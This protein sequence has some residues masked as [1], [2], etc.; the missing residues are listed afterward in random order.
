MSSSRRETLE[1]V[2]RSR[3]TPLAT[4]QPPKQYGPEV[5]GH[6]ISVLWDECAW[7]QG[8]VVQFSAI[9]DRHLVKYD[10]GDTK[11]HELGL[12]EAEGGIKWP[13]QEKATVANLDHERTAASKPPVRAGGLKRVKPSEATS[14]PSEAPSSAI[15]EAKSG[16]PKAKRGAQDER[17]ILPRKR[18]SVQANRREPTLR[19]KLHEH[20]LHPQCMPDNECDC[21]P[22]GVSCVG[23]HWRCDQC[24]F[25]VCSNC[26]EAS[27]EAEESSPAKESAPAKHNA[28]TKESA[29]AKEAASVG[30]G[31][32]GSRIEIWWPLDN[33][34][35]PAV[36]A[37][38]TPSRGRHKVIYEEAPYARA[39]PGA[40][41]N[42]VSS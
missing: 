36:V 28:P 39:P 42:D 9:D 31:V 33:A 35:Y 19:L 16:V 25:D 11:W 40:V 14:T 30:K 22:E 26:F 38:Y 4:G 20:P 34:W 23:T 21:C 32:V 5:K 37:N 7:Y 29:P 41:Y 13:G 27:G 2:R 6:R 8:V 15:S 12:E 24:D 10:D 18:Q 3:L 17:R 1:G